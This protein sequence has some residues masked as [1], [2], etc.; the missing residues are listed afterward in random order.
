MSNGLKSIALA[1]ALA[2]TSLATGAARAQTLKPAKV[3]SSALVDLM[4]RGD[5]RVIESKSLQ[6]RLYRLPRGGGC[7]AET[8]G[9]CKNS[10]FLAV[11]DLGEAPEVAVFDLGTV[12]EIASAKQVDSGESAATIE[13][14]VWS[15]PQD[16]VQH[17]VAYFATAI[18]AKPDKTHPVATKATKQTF[19]VTSTRKGGVVMAPALKP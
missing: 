3:K 7:W 2:A 12:G 15:H 9:T 10:Y 19:V 5:M 6:L 14:E 17:N 1:A 11:A 13:F 16:V 8:H 4:A 18:D